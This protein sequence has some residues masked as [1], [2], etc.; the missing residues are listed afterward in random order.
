V[1][2]ELLQPGTMTIAPGKKTATQPLVRIGS[3]TLTL[4]ASEEHRD[5]SPVESTG[6]VSS[7][8]IARAASEESA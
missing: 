7:R 3:F 5:A 1:A 4:P 8:S 6:N 2:G